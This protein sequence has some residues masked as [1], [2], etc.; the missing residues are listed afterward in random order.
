MKICRFQADGRTRY[1][2]VEEDQV[3]DRDRPEER[4]AL[5]EVRLLAPVQPRKFLAIGLNYADHIAES[6]MQAPE[7]PIFFNKQVTCVVGPGEDV[8]MPRVSNLL[9][10]EAELA[11]VI[12]TRC[13]H[14]PVEQASEMIAGYTITN[15]LSVRDWQLRTPTMTMGKSFDT[16]GPLGPWVVTPDEL[17]DP[18]GLGI[19]TFVNDE[20]RQ[21]GNTSEMVFNCFEQVAHLSEAFTLEPGDVIATGTPAGVGAVRQPF[22]EG[23]LKVGDVVRIEIDGIGELENTVVEEP[24]GYVVPEAEGAVA[25]AS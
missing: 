8:H 6:G 16:H 18:H 11:I 2:I 23:L 14:V 22:P 24:E 4:F 1:G 5:D 20:Q 9:D 25:W 17:G 21:D 3:I 7:F 15:D 13:R 19:R 10:Y 12:G